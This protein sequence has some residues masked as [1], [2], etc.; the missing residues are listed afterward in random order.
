MGAGLPSIEEKSIECEIGK[1]I[2]LEING[3]NESSKPEI[4]E[5]DNAAVK[6]NKNKIEIIPHKAGKGLVKVKYY[7]KFGPHQMEG[8]LY[9]EMIIELNIS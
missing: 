8:P 2:T 3:L 1:K 7:K 9:N 4:K 6:I 5:S